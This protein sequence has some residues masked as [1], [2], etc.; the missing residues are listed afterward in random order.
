MKT[1]EELRKELID[2]LQGVAATLPAVS[3]ATVLLLLNIAEKSWVDGWYQATLHS[4]EAI[5]HISSTA[6]VHVRVALLAELEKITAEYVRR[7][8]G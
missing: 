5:E 3:P 1:F 6:T 2:G 7:L 8:G 4:I